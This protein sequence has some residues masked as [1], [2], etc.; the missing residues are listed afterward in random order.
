MDL[1]I[2][3]HIYNSILRLRFYAFL[4]S[5]KPE[6]FEKKS[7]H[8]K[9]T[10]WENRKILITEDVESNFVHLKAIFQQTCVEIL[11]AENGKEALDLCKKH[12]DVDVVL[13]D[14]LMPEMDGTRQKS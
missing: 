5:E 11:W 7:K 2:W 6:V 1:K 4:E 13:I 9:A 10:K 14:I 3:M 12:V 8:P